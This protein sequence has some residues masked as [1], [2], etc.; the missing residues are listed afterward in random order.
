MIKKTCLAW[1]VNGSNYQATIKSNSYL[2][3]HLKKNFE[4]IYLINFYKF[5]IFRKKNET[6]ISNDIKKI[7]NLYYFCPENILQL[8]DF[9]KDKKIIGILN[10]GKKMKDLKTHIILNFF[11]IKLI[12]ASNVGNIQWS[13]NPSH[14]KK[15][16][17]KIGL[18]LDKIFFPKLINILSI[19]RLVPKVEIRFITNRSLI[20]NIKKSRLKYFLYKYKLFH[21]KELILINSRTFDHFSALSA[22]LS[23]DYIVLLDNR[24]N[25]PD[26]LQAGKIDK[27]NIFNDHYKVLIEFLKNLEKKYKKKVIISLHP[28][29]DLNY[30]K[31][32]FLNY[33]VIKFKTPELISKAFLVIFFD[34]SAIIDAIFLKKRIISL[35][36][37][38]L[39]NLALDGSNKY[40]SE[41]GI[42][43]TLLTKNLDIEPILSEVEKRISNYEKYIYRNINSNGHEKGSDKIIRIIKKRFF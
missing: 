12:Q 7:E 32:F 23:E 3:S 33:E 6:E 11:N 2:I 28:E 16:L 13:H 30:K 17:E 25:N 34:S 5:K 22:N 20:E 15:F 4:K 21:S 9:L 41:V 29:D 35:I 19:F 27:Q 10:I 43:Q 14:S 40:L 31:N 24:L 26:A 39:G 38:P 36:S 42:Y 18:K 37:K 1:I 8:K